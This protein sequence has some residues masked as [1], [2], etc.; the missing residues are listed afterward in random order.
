MEIVLKVLLPLLFVYG[1]IVGF[2]RLY[3]LLNDKITGS[4][5]LLQLVGY[6]LLLILANLLLFF[7]GLLLLFKA[8]LYLA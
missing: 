7:G 2:Y 6:A 5:S 8:Y 4:R 3:V 1:M